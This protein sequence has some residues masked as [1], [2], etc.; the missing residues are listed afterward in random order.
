MTAFLTCARGLAACRILIDFD[1]EA[2]SG[3]GGAADL[4]DEGPNV[5]LGHRDLVP[6]DPVPKDSPAQPS[7]APSRDPE[8]EKRS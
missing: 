3:L 5:V 7:P 2:S 6:R 4:P 8:L 1:R